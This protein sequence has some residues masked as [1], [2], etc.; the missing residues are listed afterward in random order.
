MQEEDEDDKDDED[1]EKP[2]DKPNI[3]PMFVRPAHLGGAVGAPRGGAGGG[4]G[5]GAL[6]EFKQTTA[7][8]YYLDCCSLGGHIPT[9]KSQ[10][11]TEGELVLATL[12]R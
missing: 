7:A 10:R 6:Y 4:D 11:K 3:H 5:R 8:Q 12:R 9:M 1:A 2:P